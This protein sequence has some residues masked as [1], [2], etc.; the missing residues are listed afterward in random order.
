MMKLLNHRLLRSWALALLGLAITACSSKTVS[1]N[2]LHSSE[3]SSLR[4]D[5][6]R[7][8]DEIT[9]AWIA[10]GNAVGVAVEV[11]EGGRIVFA[12]GF[13]QSNLQ[14]NLPVTPET[15]FKDT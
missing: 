7:H 13:G 3:M 15:Q 6:S 14:S 8:I 9:D 2:I 4:P 1:Q 11:S 5:V 10:S 12:R